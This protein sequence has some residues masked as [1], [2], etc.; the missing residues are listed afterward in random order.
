MPSLP[1]LPRRRHIALL[2]GAMIVAAAAGSAILLARSG[3]EAGRWIFQEKIRAGYTGDPLRYVDASCYGLNT[4]IY[5]VGRI[6]PSDPPLDTLREIGERCR[7]RGMHFFVSIYWL[8]RSYL[9]E[10]SWRKSVT[11]DG[12]VDQYAPPC[13]LDEEY[14]SRIVEAQ[15]VALAK[16]AAEVND[17]KPRP[18]VERVLADT[19]SEIARVVTATLDLDEVL[20]L[21]LEQLGRVVFYDSASIFL[22]QGQRLVVRAWRGFEDDEAVR[23]ISFELES[24]HIMARVAASREPLVV[25]DVQQI[26]G[27]ENA[28]GI[29]T[30]HGWIG[31]PLV[32]RGEMVGALTVDSREPGTYSGSDARIVAAFA[33]YAAIAV[34][35]ARLWQQVYRQLKEVEFL[36][37]T[38]QAIA[39]S[40][41][42][43]QVLRSLMNSVREHFRADAA[44]VALVEEGTGDLVFRVASGAAANE[45]VNVRL[46]QGQGIAGWV[47]QTGQPALIPAAREDE[48]FYRGVDEKTGFR[49]RA[50][51]AVP[52]KLGQE[53]I[54]VVEAMNPQEGEFKP[55]DLKLLMNV[56][57]LA[58]SAIQNA[59][60]FTRA[61]DAEQRYA[62]L[63]ENSADPILITDEHGLIA[64]VNR[65]L[66]EMIGREKEQLLG[67]EIATLFLNPGEM[68]EQFVRALQ[69]EGV[70]YNAE[71]VTRGEGS[72]P[73][74]IRATRVFHRGRP[75]IQWV[76][77]DLSERLELEQARQELT[78]MIIHDLRNPLS[79]I[80]SSLELIRAAT[81]DKS[82]A[83]PVDQL[84]AIAQ[85]SG[86]RLYL[87]IDSILGLARLESGEAKLDRRMVDVEEM[88]AEVV[89]QMQPTVTAREMRLESH[90][91]S[92]L[93]LLWVDRDLI[94]RVLLNLLDNAIKFTP[95]GGEIRVEVTRPDEK[96]LLFAVADT[97][98]GIPPEY[99]DHIFVRFARVYHEEARGTGLGLTFCKL[100][101]EAHGGRIWVE[102]EPGH[103]A[104]F[105]FLLPLVEKKEE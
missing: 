16:I 103:G 13:P 48:R 30:I 43:D 34:A 75:Y 21:I 33:D 76:C 14:I 53:T 81:M 52:I 19:L 65:K 102:S 41:D 18:A 35:N 9:S 32:A 27:W 73:F 91:A 68:R 84:F 31:A 61:R 37:A 10:G 49:T 78:R 94:Q 60:H 46:K 8:T 22:R 40:L 25:E 71:V 70:F 28:K 56:A 57:A 2:A 95:A 42:L 79:S 101:V 85:R 20:S 5:N 50:M 7:E 86:E 3:S 100:A 58:A 89:E 62:A 17:S 38:G 105:K 26:E 54:G 72:L 96:S 11:Q 45:V 1:G 82:I 90:F 29:H 93:P 69:G 15:S 83:V 47:A 24:G 39:A 77:H 59:R 99:H 44:S 97:G 63:F 12:F 67:Q 66:C 51:V 64:D 74:E 104:T 4:L 55:A 80:M 6:D 23:A 36:H 87:L 92:P 88:V 98:P